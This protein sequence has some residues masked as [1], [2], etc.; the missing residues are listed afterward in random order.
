MSEPALKPPRRNRTGRPKKTTEAVRSRPTTFWATT[1][2]EAAIMARAA[3]AGMSVSAYVRDAA[4]GVPIRAAR[5]DYAPEI[6]VQLR[7]AGNN[8]NQCLYEARVGNFRPSTA[9]A[10]EDALRKLEAAMHA[11]FHGD[12][13][14]D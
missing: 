4:L 7:R 2:E 10:T 9:R 14:K 8:L 11:I 6:V 12:D 5:R 1:A 3:S 13:A